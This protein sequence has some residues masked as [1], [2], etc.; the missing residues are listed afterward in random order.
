M[1]D[2]SSLGESGARFGTDADPANFE[3]KFNERFGQCMDDLRGVSGVEV[4]ELSSLLEGRVSPEIDG[5]A[6]TGFGA[7]DSER[8]FCEGRSGVPRQ[9]ALSP[10]ESV[11]V[12][13]SL[14][15]LLWDNCS[16]SL[17]AYG[18]AGRLCDRVEGG[19]D[20]AKLDIEVDLNARRDSRSR[21]MI[22][23]DETS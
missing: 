3:G 9:L 14:C 10:V 18:G 11:S 7:S 4:M 12:L 2:E 5:E 16:L 23:F 22:R 21:S 19:V 8:D 20:D 1:C 6:E 15:S 17:L 13:G